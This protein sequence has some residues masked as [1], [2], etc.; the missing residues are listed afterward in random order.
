MG[1]T[2]SLGSG[3]A[4]G[5]G[6]GT[7]DMTAISR[8][9][10]LGYCRPR[11]S[12]RAGVVPTSVPREHTY[13][14]RRA[15]TGA[16]S[17][18][19][20]RELQELPAH[21]AHAPMVVC[22][23][24]AW[25]PGDTWSWLQL[26]GASVWH[27]RG[28]YLRVRVTGCKACVDARYCSHTPSV[29]LGLATDAGLRELGAT[30]ASRRRPHGLDLESGE[31]ALDVVGKAL[32]RAEREDQ[33]WVPAPVAVKRGDTVGVGTVMTGDS[34]H[35]VAFWTHNGNLA[36]VTPVGPGAP[37]TVVAS[38]LPTVALRRNS[39]VEFQPHA[40]IP[41]DMDLWA[42]LPRATRVRMNSFDHAVSLLTC[43]RNP[44]SMLLE[45]HVAAAAC[46]GTGAAAARVAMQARKAFLLR[47]ARNRMVRGDGSWNHGARIRLG[48]LL[49]LL[50]THSSGADELEATLGDIVLA[51]TLTP[52]DA[53]ASPRRMSPAAGRRASLHDL[54]PAHAPTAPARYPTAGIARARQAA[55]SRSSIVS[56]GSG[57]SSAS[58]TSVR[59]S[60][61]KLAVV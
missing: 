18:G 15:S 57:D 19:L 60:D 4:A 37:Q 46:L 58:R 33:G 29:V 48:S 31:I 47:Q 35:L 26:T 52:D 32:E 21:A 36:H 6:C 42:A 34:D 22:P 25:G 8:I 41:L 7:E 10:S 24:G 5:T 61:A 2:S 28:S 45:A 50:V 56:S 20:E 11:K 9:R 39:C 30:E 27:P 40:A 54:R 23:T 17:G 59:C 53:P 3:A 55:L 51:E 49:R 14:S 38:L 13:L 43:V 16:E 12:F 1:C 44:S